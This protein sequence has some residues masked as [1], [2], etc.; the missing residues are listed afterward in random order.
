VAVN[1]RWASCPTISTH[2][3]PSG[4]HDA[5]EPW[6][7]LRRYPRRQYEF[8]VNRLYKKLEPQDVTLFLFGMLNHVSSEDPNLDGDPNSKGKSNINKVKYGVDAVV[9]LCPGSE[10]VFA[11]TASSRT[12]SSPRSHSRRSTPLALSHELRH[13]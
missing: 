11:S 5:V 8:H 9:D 4:H 3:A 10:P 1:S 6:Q 7:R 2:L 13:A 12:R